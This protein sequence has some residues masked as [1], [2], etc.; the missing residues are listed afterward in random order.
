MFGVLDND[1]RGYSR[2]GLDVVTAVNLFFKA[3]LLFPIFVMASYIGIAMVKHM[4]FNGVPVMNSPTPEQEQILRES[5]SQIGLPSPT[6]E[7]QVSSTKD[8][9]QIFAVTA[10][11]DPVTVNEAHVVPTERPK[12]S[13]PQSRL[14]RA[15]SEVQPYRR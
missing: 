15:L 14:D 9:P 6:V 1:G 11:A 13:A 8:E 3:V 4:L 10:K 2:G 5:D 12:P 7:E